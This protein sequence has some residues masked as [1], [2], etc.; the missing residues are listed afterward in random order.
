MS[1]LFKWIDEP[2]F[3]NPEKAASNGDKIELASIGLAA[4]L[5]A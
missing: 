1:L 4:N 2:G 5:I 3:G